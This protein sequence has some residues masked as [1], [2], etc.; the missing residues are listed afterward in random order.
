METARLKTVKLKDNLE[1][2][3]GDPI[4]WYVADGKPRSCLTYL[5]VID[6]STSDAYRLADGTR[7]IVHKHHVE[8]VAKSLQ[9]KLPVNGKYVVKLVEPIRLKALSAAERGHPYKA[10]YLQ[11]QFLVGEWRWVVDVVDGYI[12]ACTNGKIMDSAHV[13]F[14]EHELIPA[15]IDKQSGSATRQKETEAV[16]A[17]VAP[18]QDIV[19]EAYHAAKFDQGKLRA[20]L[21]RSM[22]L[23]FIELARVL[24]FGANKYAADS[25]QDVPDAIQR[26]TDAADRHDLAL[27][28]GE[29]IDDDSQCLHEAQ[30]IVNR[31]FVLE[32]KLR[33]K[34]KEVK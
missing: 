22:P 24:T 18:T 23:A 3:P 28:A 8:D 15:T 13:E 20:S 32:L 4:P 25:W 33:A 16:E 27:W 19:D 29:E 9:C 1:L 14:V 17:Y 6:D 5:E 11:P 21:L 26:Y 2:C 10:W 34:K 30:A 7:R 12:V 31:L